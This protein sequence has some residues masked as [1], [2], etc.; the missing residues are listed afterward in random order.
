ML[1]KKHSI[2]VTS[3]SITA[4]GVA[5]GDSVQIISGGAAV[6]GTPFPISVEQDP[7]FMGGGV[8]GSSEGVGFSF[9][10]FTFGPGS[11]L[12]LT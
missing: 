5:A 1:P 9:Q 7:G 3:C 8:S 10:V 6:V 11:T 4:G 2:T 12:Q